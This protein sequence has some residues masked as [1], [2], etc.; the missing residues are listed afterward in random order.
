MVILVIPVD[1]LP[2]YHKI[3]WWMRIVGGCVVK[4]LCHVMLTRHGA[5][6]ATK[7]FQETSPPIMSYHIMPPHIMACNE[8]E[9]QVHGA[10]GCGGAEGEEEAGTQGRQEEA[11]VG[12]QCSEVALTA[13]SV[14]YCSAEYL[15]KLRVFVLVHKSI[16]R[17]RIQML[18]MQTC[19][20][21]R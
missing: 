5:C 11:C 6:N 21:S 15:K 10:A 16:M 18:F 3:S 20:S 1:V 14:R 7:I 17:C 13:L 2:L 8:Q 12:P 9:T 4:A 19:S